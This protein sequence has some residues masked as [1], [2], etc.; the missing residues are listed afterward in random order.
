M[1]NETAIE[2]DIDN[3]DDDDDTDIDVLLD[4]PTPESV[5][6]AQEQ[7][8][9]KAE[10]IAETPPA[11]SLEVQNNGAEAAL[12]AVDG[13]NNP[14]QVDLKALSLNEKYVLILGEVEQSGPLFFAQ[15]NPS[16][17]ALPDRDPLNLIWINML[18]GWQI[19][20]TILTQFKA[21]YVGEEALARETT[22]ADST[23][24]KET[25][26][27]EEHTTETEVSRGETSKD[28][29]VVSDANSET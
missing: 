24:N 15:V 9:I 18:T 25:S 28:F 1:L 21:N 2:L 4:D 8:D 22:N 5:E 20:S 17:F 6:R 10:E 16:T 12:A 3:D 23:G 27:R 26:E 29:D 7:A 14:S 19:A 11:T 13:A